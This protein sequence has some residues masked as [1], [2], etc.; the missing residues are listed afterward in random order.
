MVTY[1]PY[2]PNSTI[3]VEEQIQV[4][5][6]KAF[7]RHIPK[8]GS[9]QIDGFTEVDGAPIGNQFFCDYA[10]DTLYR[11]ANRVIRFHGV[12]DFTFLTVSYIAIGTVI[13]ADDMNEIKTHMENDSIHGGADNFF[14]NVGTFVCFPYVTGNESSWSV[15]RYEHD[16][17]DYAGRPSKNYDIV[18]WNNSGMTNGW[19]IRVDDKWINL[20]V[21]GSDAW[22]KINPILS[23]K[24]RQK[25]DDKFQPAFYFAEY[26]DSDVESGEFSPALIFIQK[27]LA[28]KPANA[29]ILAYRTG[30]DERQTAIDNDEEVNEEDYKGNYQLLVR[31]KENPR[32]QVIQDLGSEW[33]DICPILT[34]ADRKLLDYLHEQLDDQI[35]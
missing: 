8:E 14:H 7:L 15:S 31:D 20:G 27:C 28:D 32:A 17:Q 22:S 12:N 34:V 9:I 11:D 13:T 4:A 1:L 33:A 35:D 29:V 24:D 25:L 3:R 19:A 16:F 18:Y 5:D 21:D 30:I 23:I 6:N 2:D 26:S 10:T